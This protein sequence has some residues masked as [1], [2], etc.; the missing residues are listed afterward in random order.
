MLALINEPFVRF[1]GEFMRALL[2]PCIGFGLIGFMSLRARAW[3][4]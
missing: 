2:C 1:V 4:K 3:G